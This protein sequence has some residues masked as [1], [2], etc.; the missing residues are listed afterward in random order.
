MDKVSRIHVTS[1]VRPTRILRILALL[2]VIAITAAIV[3]NRDRMHELKALGYCGAFLIM[4]LSNAT[5]VLPAPG[6]VFVFALG[7]SLHP[8][9][10]GLSAA[11]GATLGEITGYLT[12]YG[13][14]VMFEDTALGERLRGWMQRN[15]PLTVFVLSIIPNPIFDLAGIL[16]GAGRMSPWRFLG[17]TFCGKSIQ[18]TCIALAGSLSL[19][20]VQDLLS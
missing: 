3:L 17:V 13:G 9:L 19:G 1:T 20:W 18:A 15:G 12:G 5:L 7:G 10:I 2:L 4:L 6:L 16:A 14:L 8:L 11:A